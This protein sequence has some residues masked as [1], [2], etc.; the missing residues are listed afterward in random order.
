M[1]GFWRV[2]PN[3]STRGQPLLAALRL[4]REAVLTEKEE[5]KEDI[6]NMSNTNQPR[7]VE[8]GIL[9]PPGCASSR[10]SVIE[11]IFPLESGELLGSLFEKC[12]DPSLGKTVPL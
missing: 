7:R 8:G 9:P 10:L 2:V 6:R 12:Y 5:E 1:L 4:H 11:E 3:V